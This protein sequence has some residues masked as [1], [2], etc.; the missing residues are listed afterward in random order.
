[1]K[2]RSFPI[3]KAGCQKTTFGFIAHVDDDQA[4]FGHTG[5]SALFGIEMVLTGSARQNFAGA[6]NLE[7]F[8][9]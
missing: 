9:I 3:L 5:R 7:S 8:Q 6:G 1:M 2:F 4:M